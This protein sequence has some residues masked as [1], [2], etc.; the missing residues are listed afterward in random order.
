MDDWNVEHVAAW[1]KPLKLSIDYTQTIIR[2]EI[3][4]SGLKAIFEEDG[5]AEFGFDRK[6]D[7]FKIK[8]AMKKLKS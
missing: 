3:D 1:M 4:G 2:G 8:A 7:I 6:M 5:W